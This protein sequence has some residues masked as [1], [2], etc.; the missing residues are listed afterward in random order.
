[1]TKIRPATCVLVALLLCV[2]AYLPG[3]GGTYEFD[4]YPNIVDNTALHLTTLDA[5]SLGDAI[6]SSPSSDLQRPLSSLSFALNHYFTGL[7]PLPMKLTNLAIHLLDGLLLFLLLRRIVGEVDRRESS[8]W[9]APLVT[10]IWLLHPINLTAVL[11]VVQRMESI[12]QAFVLLGLLCYVGARDDHRRGRT[13]A[14]RWQLW[15]GVPLC[16]IAGIAAKESAA[17]LPV[18]AFVLE[19]AVFRF[20]DVRKVE[21]GAFFTAFLFAP[22]VLGLAWLAPKVMGPRAYAGRDFTL[23]ERLLTEPRVL[24]D[25]ITWILLPVPKFFSFFRDD[26]P[27]SRD[28]LHPWTTLPAIAGVVAL[29]ALAW[30]VRRTRPL[31]A[32]GV[33]WFFAAHLLTATVVPLE[34]AFEHRNYFASAGLL[35]ALVDLLLPVA[36]A[37]LAAARAAA[38]AALA[39]L[40]VFTLVLRAHEWS[41][42]V[43]LAVTEA[44]LHPAS[45]RATYALGRTYVILSGYQPDSPNVDKAIGALETAARVPNAGILPEVALITLASRTG[46]PIDAAWWDGIDAKLRRR[47]PTPEDWTAVQSLTDCQRRGRCVLDDGRTLQMYLAG[48][49]HQPPVPSILYSYAIFAFNRLHDEKLALSLTRTAAATSSDL[50]Y[51]VNLVNFLIDL[52]RLDEARAELD[53]LRAKSHFGMMHREIAA[54][55]KRLAAARAAPPADDGA[56]AQ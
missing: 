1:M 43:R 40:A 7:D 16:T 38:L 45:P 39:C 49:E 48:L 18:F 13:A 52:G 3:L 55:G 46:R 41:D 54:L 8:R 2:L 29:L 12:A 53:A 33:A 24:F 11:Y 56:A 25:Y 32:L 35:L 10:A 15:L 20:R 34:I 14:A 26:Y 4:D 28:L 22:A 42:P 47:R 37:P 31:V 5:T 23:A 51:R 50:Q 6:W 21:I 17:L 30:R 19:C 9:I 27:V 44:S 36:G